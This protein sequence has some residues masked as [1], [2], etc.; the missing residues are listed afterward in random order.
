LASRLLFTPVVVCVALIFV[1]YSSVA[2]CGSWI[3]VRMFLVR[4]PVVH[5]VLCC[6][7]AN[8]RLTLL[9]SHSLL[10]VISKTDKAG[11]GSEN[12]FTARDSPPSAPSVTPRDIID[13]IICFFVLILLANSWWRIISCGGGDPSEIGSDHQRSWDPHI[14]SQRK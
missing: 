2:P 11:N 9:L 4:W 8:L 5:C 7:F 14:R 12:N 13:N 6:V 3:P 1:S 10:I